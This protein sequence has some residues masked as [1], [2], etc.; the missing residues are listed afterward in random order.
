M[1]LL[2]GNFGAHGVVAG[3]GLLA[4]QHLFEHFAVRVGGGHRARL[5]DRLAAVLLGAAA[6]E[7]NLRGAFA[8]REAAALPAHVALLDDVLT[9]GATLHA[10]A[11]ALHDAGVARI[12]AWVCARVL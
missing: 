6:R 2:V 9:T 1:G 5:G 12:D 11:Q 10:A 8:V 7:R 3:G 4:R